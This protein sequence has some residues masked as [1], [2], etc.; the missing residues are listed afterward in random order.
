M[1]NQFNFLKNTGRYVTGQ[2]TKIYVSSVFDEAQGG[3]WE[4]AETILY[5]AKSIELDIATDTIPNQDYNSDQILRHPVGVNGTGTISGA[6]IY[7]DP[8]HELMVNAFLTKKYVALNIV[9]SS[10]VAEIIACKVTGIRRSRSVNNF[11]Q[12]A[13]SLAGIISN[14]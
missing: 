14:S 10:Q 9:D 2:A 12:I 1:S 6:Q 11:N 8:G 7:S 13:Y 5:S 3:I 4:P